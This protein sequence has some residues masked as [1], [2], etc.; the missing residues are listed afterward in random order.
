M[1]SAGLVLAV[2]PAED[3]LLCAGP[4]PGPP[5]DAALQSSSAV[6]HAVPAVG[7]HC[8][9]IEAPSGSESRLVPIDRHTET[10]EDR[11]DR[12]DDR[13]EERPGKEEPH[14]LFVVAT[15]TALAVD[16]DQ[17]PRVAAGAKRRGSSRVVPP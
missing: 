9:A 6:R 2:F 17:R 10:G 3:S 12:A 11:I 7:L 16:H 5:H 15:R 4:A 13:I 8:F 14:R 1:A